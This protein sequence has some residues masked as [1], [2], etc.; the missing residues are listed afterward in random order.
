MG[1][2]DIIDKLKSKG[3]VFANGLTEE[4]FSKVEN[5]Y[6]I[7]FPKELKNFLAEG[8]PFAEYT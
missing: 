7:K 5:L 1:F 2:K 6:N 4:E 8:L 3:I